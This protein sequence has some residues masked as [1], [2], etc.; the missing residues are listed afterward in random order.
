MATVNEVG[1][2]LGA[3]KQAPMDELNG[4]LAGSTGGDLT[5]G[6]KTARMNVLSDQ[7]AFVR[8]AAE[9]ANKG[10]TYQQ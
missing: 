3:A 7:L 9:L 4:L 5:T 8:S 6:Q 1:A 10:N 2:S